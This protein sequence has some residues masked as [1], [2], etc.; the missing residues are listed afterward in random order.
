ME[1][2]T[3]IDGLEVLEE[4][5]SDGDAES[6]VWP[7]FYWTE[8]DLGYGLSL[9]VRPWHNMIFSVIGQGSGCKPS[10]ITFTPRLCDTCGCLASPDKLVAIMKST[11]ETG[12]TGLDVS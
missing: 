1:G 9:F 2:F 8:L 4:I 10:V 7:S 6:P 5:G 11:I 12:L 3:V